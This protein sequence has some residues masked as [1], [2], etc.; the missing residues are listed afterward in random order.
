MDSFG[1]NII[2]GGLSY[3]YEEAPQSTSETS[4]IAQTP[5]KNPF[6]NFK[7]PELSHRQYPPTLDSGLFFNVLLPTQLNTWPAWAAAIHI[8]MVLLFLFGMGDFMDLRGLFKGYLTNIFVMWL[9]IVA[10]AFIF[11]GLPTALA[12]AAVTLGILCIDNSKNP[13]VKVLLI[14]FGLLH[15]TLANL[16]TQ[17]TFSDYDVVLIAVYLVLLANVQKDADRSMSYMYRPGYNGSTMKGSFKNG[18]AIEDV[19]SGVSDKMTMH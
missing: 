15:L 2:S 4:N 10:F 5:L 1:S 3:I 16:R 19:W 9:L 17:D 7:L 18:A 14:G 13:I 11:V 12:I 8:F 6:A